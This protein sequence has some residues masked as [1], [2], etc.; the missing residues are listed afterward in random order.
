MA[1]AQSRRRG[2]NCARWMASWRSFE[3]CRCLIGKIRAFRD[4]GLGL[5]VCS[6]QPT[7]QGAALETVKTFSGL[8]WNPWTFNTLYFSGHFCRNIELHVLA[9]LSSRFLT[10]PDLMLGSS[11]GP[12]AGWGSPSQGNRGTYGAHIRTS[13]NRD[14]IDNHL[15]LC[16]FPC[17][18]Y[19]REKRAETE[20]IHCGRFPNPRT[21]RHSAPT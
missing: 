1:Y 7:Y 18:E 4:S 17:L 13:C 19:R 10:S 15:A 5:Y 20:I 21:T 8:D 11:L 6:L 16:F 2:R 9:W 12:R 14:N 3:T